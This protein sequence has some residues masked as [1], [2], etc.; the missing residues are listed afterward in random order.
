VPARATLFVTAAAVALFAGLVA[1][2]ARYW[3]QPPVGEENY[4]SQLALWGYR[5]VPYEPQL[6]VGLVGTTPLGL[7]AGHPSP[8]YWFFY[9]VG[10]LMR[11]GGAMSVATFQAALRAVLSVLLAA[12]VAIAFLLCVPTRRPGPL[13]GLAVAC[14]VLFSSPYWV[15]L[16]I[17]LQQDGVATLPYLMWFAAGMARAHRG[18]TRGLRALSFA[19]ALLIGGDKPERV[20]LLVAAGVGAAL[21]LWLRG[22]RPRLDHVLPDLAGLGTGLALILVFDHTHWIESFSVAHEFA[23]ANYNRATAFTYL[24]W[25]SYF[26]PISVLGLAVVTVAIRKPAA[27]DDRP[28]FRD[29]HLA[30]FVLLTLAATLRVH[31]FGDQFPRY[32]GTVLAMLQMWMIGQWGA[33]VE[34]PPVGARRLVAV[35]LVPLAVLALVQSRHFPI[36]LERSITCFYGARIS[37]HPTYEARTDCVMRVVR[38]SMNWQQGSWVYSEYFGVDAESR[39]KGIHGQPFCN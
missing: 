16:S 28:R 6:P 23:N 21:Y 17:Q 22:R 4:F 11:V 12:T 29:A 25:V 26:I 10:Q 8:P 35:L 27:G 31:W 38:E 3:S 7:D 30:G 34:A 18:E 1:M 37:P 32:F 15:G 39:A 14:V 33:L 2:R 24:E 13:I 5:G 9:R 36:P 20:A 19:T